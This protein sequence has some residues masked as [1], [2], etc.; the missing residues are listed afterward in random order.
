[1]LFRPILALASVLLV[2]MGCN[3]AQPAAA[4]SPHVDLPADMRTALTG[5]YGN[6]EDV[7]S[8][9]GLISDLQTA[10]VVC[11]GEAHYDERDMQTAFEIVQELAAHRKLALAVER[12]SY[13]LQPR[14]D[15]LNRMATAEQRQTEIAAIL[16]SKDYQTVWGMHSF[17][18]SGFPV[19][20]PSQPIF[21]AM[22]RWAVQ[23]RIPL[24]GLDV[25]LAERTSGLGEDIPYR[26]ELWASRINSF[27][28]TVAGTGYLVVVV[29]GTDH[30][31]N[32]SSSLPSQLKTKPFAKIISIG[33]RDALYK[34][35]AATRVQDYAGALGL[36]DVIVRHP[37]FAI[38][39]S[40]GQAEYASPADY[41]IAVHA[42]GTL[43]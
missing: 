43:N 41:W 4:Q 1:M 10:D 22:V 5:E 6:Y 33:Q 38:V 39:R 23:N 27:L 42:D 15:G 24:I 9:S 3:L 21:E 16:E 29:G 2:V 12:F 8:W 11:I 25:S 7:S 26:N 13:D 34:F 35:T 31:T 28:A 40:D 18:Q 14:L 19:N 32:A 30:M 20:T 37:Q 17:D 36:S